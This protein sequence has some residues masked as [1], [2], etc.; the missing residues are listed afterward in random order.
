MCPDDHLPCI[1]TDLRLSR[2]TQKRLV[3]YQHDYLKNIKPQPTD[4]NFSHF[5]SFRMKLEWLSYS[6]PDLTCAVSVL[7]QVIEAGFN[8]RL[9]KLVKGVNKILLYEREKPVQI[10]FKHIEL[11]SLHIDSFSDAS[12]DKIVDFF[13]QLRLSSL[14]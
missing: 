9:P 8:S 1:L 14:S 13:T 11:A 10:V 6:R 12:F 5:R 7:A 2:N 4:S 3:L